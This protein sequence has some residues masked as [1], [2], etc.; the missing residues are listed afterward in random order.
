MTEEQGMKFIISK[1]A[2]ADLAA[3]DVLMKRNSRTLGFLP[4][5]ALLEYLQKGEVFG[6]KTDDGQLIGYLLYASNPKYFRITHLC[7][8]EEIRNQGLARQFINK[9]KECV[10]TQKSIRLHCRRD[11]PAH[12]MWPELGFIALDEQ[13]GRSAAGHLLT[14]WYLTLA[15]DDQLDLFQANTSDEALD[16]VIDAQIFF[17]FYEPNTAKTK[18][19]K[20]LF[21][22]FPKDS[23]NLWITDELFNEINRKNDS[24]KRN[25][26][27]NSAQGFSRVEP[28]LSIVEHFDTVLRRNL[29]HSTKSQKSDIRHLANTAASEIDT[30][31]T[32]DQ[33]LLKNAA[34]IFELSDL[35]VLSPTE[36]IIQLHEIS[37][38]HTYTPSRVSGNRLAWRRLASNDLAT[39]PL[40]SF[41]NQGERI[42]QFREHLDSYLAN[43][44]RYECVL[45]RSE[46]QVIAIQVR[47]I[48]DDKILKVHL[49][50]VART[51]DQ[52][53]FRRYL[54]TNTIDIAVKNKMYVVIFDEA[55]IAP[56]FTSDL[57]DTG[58][59]KCEGIFVR[60]CFSCC[61]EHEELLDKISKFYPVATGNYE[62]MTVHELERHCS[63]VSLPTTQDNFLVP[64]R[65]GYAIS[66]IDTRQAEHELF[67]GELSV[68]LRWDNVYYRKKNLHN[69][70]QA[71]ARILWY[72]SKPKKANRSCITS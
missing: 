4:K 6:A 54:V 28:T 23:L 55:N 47:E 62:G 66:L 60:F 10:T 5:K 58:F 7:I 2:S 29:H 53:L 8:S 48:S 32:R 15:P 63:P 33:Y 13:R 22:D 70:L 24:G 34:K 46:N 49:A 44:N 40:D 12:E 14:H 69:M 21:A 61:F 3:V 41:L 72:V 18:P 17:N 59:T 39:F 11:Y 43:P 27:R 35:K 19:S 38:S 52:Q 56:G 51:A 9:L 36:L 25:I 16:V 30:F 65:H 1:L 26:S 57:L 50:R 64:V 68:L 37:D 67:G 20:A 42:G 31:V 71:P 45:L